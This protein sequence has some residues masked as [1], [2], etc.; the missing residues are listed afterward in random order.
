MNSTKQYCLLVTLEYNS[1]RKTLESKGFEQDDPLL[2][3]TDNK[4]VFLTDKKI[5]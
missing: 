4:F 3:A 2:L 1:A 5:K